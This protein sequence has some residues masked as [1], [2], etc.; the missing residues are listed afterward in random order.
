MSHALV[1]YLQVR[2]WATTLGVTCFCCCIGTVAALRPHLDAH[3]AFAFAAWF[4][5]LGGLRKCWVSGAVLELGR[6]AATFVVAV[7]R[8]GVLAMTAAGPDGEAID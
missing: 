8:G 4:G 2:L 6:R 1:T 7:L 5:L 3:D